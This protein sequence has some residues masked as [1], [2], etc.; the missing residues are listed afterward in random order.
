MLFVILIG[1][2]AY[3]I[4]DHIHLY[5][6]NWFRKYKRK[7]FPCKNI[8]YIKTEEKLF[9]LVIFS[10]LYYNN[11]VKINCFIKNN[12]DFLLLKNMFFK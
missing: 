8:W 4:K 6:S 11:D 12:V 10:I 3:I 7:Y 2:F 1:V 9:I 5:K